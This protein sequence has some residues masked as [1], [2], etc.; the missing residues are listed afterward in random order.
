MMNENDTTALAE[1]ATTIVSAYVANN[2][3]PMAELPALIHSIHQS[4]GRLSDTTAVSETKTEELKPA[5]AVKKSVTEDYIISLEDG[6]KFKSL[7]RHLAAE[8]GMTPEQYRAKWGLPNN[9]PM[10]APAYAK[11]RSSLAKSLGLGRKPASAAPR[12]AP[13]LRPPPMPKPSR[14]NAQRKR[15]G[16]A[17]ADFRTSASSMR[18]AGAALRQALRTITFLSRVATGAW[19]TEV[20]T[21]IDDAHPSPSPGIASCRRRWRAE[22]RAPMCS[23]IIRSTSPGTCATPRSFP[24]GR[25]QSTHRSERSAAPARWP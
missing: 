9:Y 12:G 15:P 8:Y 6:R 24:P 1:M 25:R 20:L 10:V 7:K 17:Q 23:S 21:P 3:I 16:N 11:Q 5:V 14:G 2:S 18:H 13:L 22:I 4:L 19:S